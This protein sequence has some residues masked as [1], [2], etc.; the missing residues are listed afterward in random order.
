MPE[1]QSTGIEQIVGALAGA[2][3]SAVPSRARGEGGKFAGK[4]Q[5]P[6]AQDTQSDE[7]VLPDGH[8]AKREPGRE[9]LA[10]I[11]ER[12]AF[13]KLREHVAQRNGHAE[14]KNGKAEK[15]EAPKEAARGDDDDEHSEADEAAEQP[16]GKKRASDAEIAIARAALIRSG[17]RPKEVDALPVSELVQRGQA[18]QKRLAEADRAFE[19]VRNT[20][21]KKSR[22]AD[23]GGSEAEQ[24]A[25]LPTVD[26]EALTSLAKTLGLEG[27]EAKS[28]EGAMTSL[29]KPLLDRIQEQQKQLDGLVGNSTNQIIESARQQLVGEFPE[30]DD[31]ERQD[32]LTEAMQA[33]SSLSKYRGI[34]ASLRATALMRDACLAC[35][36]THDNSAEDER[37]SESEREVRKARRQ[38]GRPTSDIRRTP[39]TASKEEKD[40]AFFTAIR[41]GTDVDAASRLAGLRS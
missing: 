29:V 10:R 24:A 33:L 34:P 37:K 25:P 31:A 21:S 39:T 6:A 4:K 14:P 16:A 20:K 23:D 28:L 11:E 38:H 12:G 17:F 35:G 41:G 1:N 13:D 27:S 22:D 30:L 3:H 9:P 8:P 32:E 18:A 15:A 19:L 36:F 5:T 40:R 26:P 7:D 2:A